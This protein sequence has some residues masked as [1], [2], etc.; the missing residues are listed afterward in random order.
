MANA[1]TPP[2]LVNSIQRAAP[3]GR[4]TPR[5]M[6][7]VG[8]ARIAP[9]IRIAHRIRHPIAIA[10]RI[11]FDHELVLFLA[12]RGRFV[13]N[14]TVYAIAP[15]SL[16]LI[17]PFTPHTIETAPG[18]P[19]EHI[20][21]HFDLTGD[22]P[23]AEQPSRRTPYAIRLPR[24]LH[25]PRHAMLQP[26]DRLEDAFVQLLRA[27][28]AI[29]PLAPLD[30]R[31]HLLAILTQLLRLGSHQQRQGLDPAH[32]RHAEARIGRAIE[33]AASHL[34]QKLAADDLAAAAG[35]SLSHFTRM[36]HAWTGYAPMEY[37]RRLRIERARQLLGDLDLSIKQIAHRT[38]FDDAYHFSKVFRK[39]QGLPPT[40]Y[41]ESLLTQSP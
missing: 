21:I 31:S 12:G 29:D 4:L 5:R 7:A 35:L 3:F 41:R 9:H 2:S 22:L 11:I 6:V 38:G 19:C 8:L 10:Q 23:H 16:F 15:H 18:I 34:A 37:L 39:L 13:L 24:G 36:F 17:P 14:S 20:A 40:A 30:A 27:H 33:F 28:A 1:G 25:F 32:R 26:H